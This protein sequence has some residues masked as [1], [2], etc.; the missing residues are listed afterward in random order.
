MAEGQ[1]VFR[2]AR[3]SVSETRDLASTMSFS[4]P[5]CCI[6]TGPRPGREARTNR[7]SLHSRTRSTVRWSCKLGCGLI[8]M[9]SIW[10]LMRRASASTPRRE[11]R[12]HQRTG[13]E[14][15]VGGR[16]LFAANAHRM[17]PNR[18]VGQALEVERDA[19][20][21]RSRAAK[22]AD[23]MSGGWLKSLHGSSVDALREYV[24]SSCRSKTSIAP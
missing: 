14:R 15:G 16:V 17:H 13:V 23:M 3:F 20:A 11:E 18:L 5:C 2:Q 19:H 7:P 6:P 10:R 21:V 8:W 12:R 24:R 9:R 22:Y 1:A 4:N